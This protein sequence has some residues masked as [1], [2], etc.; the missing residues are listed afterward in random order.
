MRMEWQRSLQPRIYMEIRL[1][2]TCTDCDF[3]LIFDFGMN[4][5]NLIIIIYFYIPKLLLCNNNS[6]VINAINPKNTHEKLYLYK[7]HENIY[8]EYSMNIT[9]ISISIILLSTSTPSNMV[10]LH[11]ILYKLSNYNSEYPEITHVKPY[12]YKECEEIGELTKQSHIGEKPFHCSNCDNLYKYSKCREYMEI[13]IN[14]YLTKYL[15]SECDKYI[16]NPAQLYH[17]GEKPCQCNDCDKRFPCC[18]YLEYTQCSNCDNQSKYSNCREHME[19]SLNQYLTKVLA[20]E[21]DKFKFNSAHQS[22]IGEK[23]FQCNDCNSRFIS[24]KYQ[25]YKGISQIQYLTKYPALECDKYKLA[26]VQLNTVYLLTAKHTKC[27]FNYG[28][29]IAYI[30]EKENIFVK[31]INYTLHA[32]RRG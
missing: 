11:Y 1:P 5:H 24:C 23:P 3:D 14:Q 15:A 10:I 7:E 16:A 20:P 17:I 19:I 18:K 28:L 27:D 26:T 2:L 6:S 25:E 29:Y 30:N 4:T 9:N 21:C 32:T 12:H 8:N 22:H 31:K 13:S